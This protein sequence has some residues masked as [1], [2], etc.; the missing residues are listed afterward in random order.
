MVT[1]KKYKM[2]KDSLDGDDYF[3]NGGC[4]RIRYMGIGFH[5]SSG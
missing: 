1:E 3:R 5:V 2:L 4:Y